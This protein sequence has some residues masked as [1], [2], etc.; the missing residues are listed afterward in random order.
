MKE[1][2]IV[3]TNKIQD[4]I[5]PYIGK[6]FP[7]CIVGCATST[8]RYSTAAGSQDNYIE[9]ET[10][11]IFDIA[12]VTK[13]MLNVLTLKLIPL[14]ELD[15]K[16]ID[17]IPMKGKYRDL[18]TVRH[19]L[20]FSV[21]YGDQKR[22]SEIEIKEELMNIITTGD[23]PR[24]PGTGFRYTNISSMLLTFFLEEKFGKTFDV[25]LMEKLF[26]PLNMM[27]TTFPD[28]L[29]VKNNYSYVQ[30][31]LMLARGVVQDESARLYGQPTGS[32][33]LFSTIDDLLTFGQSFLGED[34]F[35]PK[36]VIK[37]MSVS[38]LNNNTALTFGLGMGLRHQNE[39]DVCDENGIPMLVLKKNGFSGVHFCV[40]PENDFCFVAFGNI[41]HPQRPS[42]EK[43]DM[44]TNFH[45]R[46]IALMH[47][48]QHE[49][50]V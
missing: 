28:P 49:L 24:L 44:F 46:L 39:C 25:L 18:I 32:A 41:C 4:F 10:D 16:I 45:K 27:E 42:A 14:N 9:M 31:E 48:N 12:S 40:M 17:V 38:Q 43:R 35:L 34:T 19:L 23:L 2:A 8:K 33:G 30:T 29:E 5:A 13:A 15:Q 36:N 22:L 26:S 47:E 3:T 7:G 37:E 1:N 6:L 20:S 21:E 11:D 50:L